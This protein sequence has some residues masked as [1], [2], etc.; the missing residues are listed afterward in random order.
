MSPTDDSD[1]SK[2][3]V[4]AAMCSVISI[5]SP[6]RSFPFG[7]MR[8]KG[9]TA[10]GDASQSFPVQRFQ[11]FGEVAVTGSASYKKFTEQDTRMCLNQAVYGDIFEIWGTYCSQL[12]Y[13]IYGGTENKRWT[14][15]NG[16]NVSRVHSPI[17]LMQCWGR[18]TQIYHY[19]FGTKHGNHH[20]LFD[21]V[22]IQ[23]I[24]LRSFIHPHSPARPME[25][26]CDL[27]KFCF[28]GLSDTWHR[29]W[30][31]KECSTVSMMR[32]FGSI[33]VFGCLWYI[34]KIIKTHQKS[35]NP[36]EIPMNSLFISHLR[37]MV[38]SLQTNLGDHPTW[39]PR[40][41]WRPPEPRP[42][43]VDP[44][45]NDYSIVGQRW[46][47]I[48]IYIYLHI[49][50]YIYHYCMYVVFICIITIYNIYSYYIYLYIVHLN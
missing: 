9:S 22:C 14:T 44:S 45:D 1:G 2:P 36:Y 6:G 8:S 37:P 46:C 13:D 47:G 35:W 42:M 50:I 17:P 49:Q 12:G 34:Y 23:R 10:S 32:L 39:R 27:N 19:W 29:C 31:A 40:S 4:G 43:W 3:D 7:E 18:K 20:V 48:L 38:S 26:S 24:C 41:V 21:C 16:M 5:S 11:A 25:E 28:H 33:D 30:F 15:K